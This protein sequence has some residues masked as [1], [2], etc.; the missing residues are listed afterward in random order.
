MDIG[1]GLASSVSK[2]PGDCPSGLPAHQTR[3]ATARLAALGFTVL[4]GALKD[5]LRHTEH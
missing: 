3:E 5:F 4:R 2:P 1:P